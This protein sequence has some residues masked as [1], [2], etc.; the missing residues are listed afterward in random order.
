M[1]LCSGCEQYS[2]DSPKYAII[3]HSRLS[4]PARESFERRFCS[5]S[6]CSA[7]LNRQMAVSGPFVLLDWTGSS[8]RQ[9]EPLPPRELANTLGPNHMRRS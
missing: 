3:H 4:H 9:S 1:Y 6:C 5:A 8:P 7:F 2:Y